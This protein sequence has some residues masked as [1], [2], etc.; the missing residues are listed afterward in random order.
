MSMMKS[1]FNSGR[2][3]PSKD[4]NVA[5][6]PM[7]ISGSKTGKDN[8]VNNEFLTPAFEIIADITVEETPIP[9]LPKKITIMNPSKFLI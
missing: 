4:I 8:T 1:L 3:F 7:I 9:M 5:S 6:I 2:V